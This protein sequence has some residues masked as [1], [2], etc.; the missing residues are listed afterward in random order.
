[1]FK[2]VSNRIKFLAKLYPERILELEKIFDAKSFVYIDYANVRPWSRKLGWRI[3]LR[4]LKQFLS[5]FT[6]VGEVKIYYGTLTGNTASEY[7]ISMVNSLGYKVKTKPVKILRLSIDVTSIAITS[8][9]LLKDFVRKPLLAI[10]TIK[11]I[12]TLNLELKHLNQQGVMYVEDYKSNFDVEIGRDML[13]DYHNAEIS[14]CILW[15]GDSDFTS[16]VEELL[17]NGK[18]VVLF[19]TARRVSTEL[20]QLRS[21]GLAIFDIQKIKEFICHKKEMNSNISRK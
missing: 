9:D 6:T 1:M 5:S 11:T 19:A 16:P 15:S 17:K 8:L 20:N 10:L 4:R 7:V 14:N 21:K 3:D 2:P 13:L 18:K 12:E